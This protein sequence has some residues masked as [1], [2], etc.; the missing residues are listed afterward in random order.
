M[1]KGSVKHPVGVPGKRGIGNPGPRNGPGLIAPDKSERGD[2]FRFI[3]NDILPGIFIVGIACF[4]MIK[5]RMMH[6]AG[7]M[8]IPVAVNAHRS[9]IIPGALVG[10]I[11]Y[12]VFRNRTI[13]RLLDNQRL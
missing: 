9:A 4:G 12:N 5:R 13:G 6:I 7:N 10:F 2:I 1:A 8:N 11:K 3:G